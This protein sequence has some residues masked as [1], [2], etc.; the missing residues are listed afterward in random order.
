MAKEKFVVSAEYCITLDRVDES[1]Y[2]EIA[3]NAEQWQ[4]WDDLGF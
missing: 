3:D 4:Q 2:A 1:L